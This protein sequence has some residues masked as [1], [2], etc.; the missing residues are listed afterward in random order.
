LV[1]ES[2]RQVVE[3]LQVG[4]TMAEERARATWEKAQ[5]SLR[6]PVSSYCRPTNR[7]LSPGRPARRQGDQSLPPRAPRGSPGEAGRR[8]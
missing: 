7:Q 3:L 2:S 8:G 5:G 4:Q 1:E 6:E